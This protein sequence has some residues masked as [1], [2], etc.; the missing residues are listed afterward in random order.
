VA[1]KIF[2]TDQIYLKRNDL[3]LP[4]CT[5]LISVYK[6]FQ[7]TLRKRSRQERDEVQKSAVPKPRDEH[8]LGPDNYRDNAEIDVFLA[9][10][11]ILMIR[12]I[13]GVIFVLNV[14]LCCHFRFALFNSYF[15]KLEM[16]FS[17]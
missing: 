6:K 9:S 5:Y 14:N 2:K 17:F 8:F 16:L 12:L 3:N 1:I 11:I 15:Q 10:L 7:V 4:V 13:K